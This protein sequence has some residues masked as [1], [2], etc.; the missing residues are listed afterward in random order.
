M[1]AVLLLLV[2]A[3]ATIIAGSHSGE[4]NTC[5]GPNEEFQLCSHPEGTCADPAPL[6]CPLQCGPLKC[7]CSPGFVRA[8]N[9]TCILASACPLKGFVKSLAARC[10]RK[11]E[12]MQVCSTPEGTCDAPLP[13][14]NPAEP[15]H[16][17]GPKCQCW[18]GHVR[19]RG[20]C[21]PVWECPGAGANNELDKPTTTPAAL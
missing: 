12:A 10:L 14:V 13:D 4:T 1:P 9:G 11:N 2:A 8:D 16:F 15:A 19:H 17:D 20:E 6:Y 3:A 18:P 21:I 5:I 7:L